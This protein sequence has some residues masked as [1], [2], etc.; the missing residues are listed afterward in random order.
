MAILALTLK[1]IFPIM[2]KF[3]LASVATLTL[4]GGLT[5]TSCK[6]E[7]KE[8]RKDMLVGTWRLVQEGEDSNGNGKFDA[9]EKTT[10][11]PQDSYTVQFNSDGTG[12]TTAGITLPITWSLQN[13]DKD[14]QMTIVTTSSTLNI[15]EI[16]NSSLTLKDPT[17]SPAEFI[18]LTTQ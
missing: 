14:L 8:N 12:N 2:K 3:I 10:V 1:F 13:G 11:N 4:L 5:T 7:E 18:T 17:E 9:D 6:K 16:S 15:V